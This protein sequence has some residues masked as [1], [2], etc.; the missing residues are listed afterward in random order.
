[1]CEACGM[2][3]LKNAHSILSEN[4][5]GYCGDNLLTS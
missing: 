4:L 5:K 2:G 1:M 3:E